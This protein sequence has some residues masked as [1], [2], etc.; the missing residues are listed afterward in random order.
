MAKLKRSDFRPANEWIEALPEASRHRAKA[1]AARAVE[2][3]H[4]AEVRKALTITQAALADRTG[5]KQTEVSRIE[6]NPASV[7]IR[8]LDRY[9]AG[10]GGKLKLVAEFPD[11]TQAAIP[12]Q[13]GKP[14]KSRATVTH[15]RLN[16]RLPA[17][18]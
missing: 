9:V 10:L 13:D 1:A 11:G 18:S 14:V 3:I 6:N 16:P 5:L 12:L 8:T 7:Q 2:A 4:L 15:D 17:S